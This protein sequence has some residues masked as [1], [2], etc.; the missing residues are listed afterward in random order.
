MRAYSTALS[1]FHGQRETSLKVMS[2]YLKGIDSLI[3][4][5]SYEAFKA[6]IPEIPYVNQAG[7]ESAIQ[8]TPLGG[9]EKAIKVADI[10]D[11]SFVRE[12]EQQGFYRALY[13]R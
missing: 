11:E 5:K 10:V 12:L 3:L 6:W 7:M 8:L 4:E 2:R 1:V 9:K 13:K